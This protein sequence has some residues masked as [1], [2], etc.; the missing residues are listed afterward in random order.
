MCKAH[1]FL[2]LSPFSFLFIDLFLAV[3]G[4]HCCAGFSP[5]EAG[6][7]RSLVVVL[8]LPT[9]AASPVAGQGL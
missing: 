2:S 3:L 9:V 5:V 4:L 7:G 8:R 1:G 6:G